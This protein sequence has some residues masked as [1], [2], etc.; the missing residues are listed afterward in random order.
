MVGVVA[1]ACDPYRRSF[2]TVSL[3]PC[4]KQPIA[5]EDE[6]MEYDIDDGQGNP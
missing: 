2:S 3:A 1:D 6:A 4:F 5:D